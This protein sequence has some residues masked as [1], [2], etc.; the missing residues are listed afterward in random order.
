MKEKNGKKEG[1]FRYENKGK[2]KDGKNK[3]KKVRNKGIKNKLK[4]NEK[5]E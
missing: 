5:R 1:S 2:G 4:D 3:K